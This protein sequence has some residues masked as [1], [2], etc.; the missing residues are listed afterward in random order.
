[1][2]KFKDYDWMFII[3]LASSAIVSVFCI[4][5]AITESIARFQ[6]DRTL[7]SYQSS[8]EAF[9]RTIGGKIDASY[10]CKKKIE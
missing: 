5:L 2:N 1:M 9:N 4:Y 10:T 6:A 7:Q 8:Y 3:A